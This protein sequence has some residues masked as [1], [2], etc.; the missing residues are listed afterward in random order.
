DRRDAAGVA[1]GQ[2]RDGVHIEVA[3]EISGTPRQG[4]GGGGERYLEFESYAIFHMP[5]LIWH[6]KYGGP[7]LSFCLPHKHKKKPFFIFGKVLNGSHHGS[8]LF[9]C[10]IAGSRRRLSAASLELK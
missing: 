2:I 7:L 9:G 4:I 3:S 1:L 5:L 6:M 10:V 8:R